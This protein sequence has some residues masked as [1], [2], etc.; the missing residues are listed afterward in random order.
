MNGLE[1]ITDRIAADAQ[2]EADAILAD[3]K[4]QAAAIA[5]EAQ[6][7]AAAEGADILAKG[8]AAAAERGERIASMAQLEG[9]KRVLAAKQEMLIQAFDKA[10]MNLLAMP[11]EQQIDLL[12]NMAAQAAVTGRESVMFNAEDRKEI[13]QAVVAKANELLAKEVAPKL[14]QEATQGKLGALLETAVN[15]VSAIAK[16]TAMLTLSDETRPI[17]GGFILESGGVEINC[18]YETLVRL[19][20]SEL[21]RQVAKVL[22]DA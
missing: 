6:A 20:R 15:T 16:G 5:A 21:E 19:S 11:K 14:P 8:E 9:R 22:F 2:A 1:K 10:L 4:A 18:A 17:T 13:G 7:A 12:A 3:A